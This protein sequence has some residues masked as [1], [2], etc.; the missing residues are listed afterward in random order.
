MLCQIFFWFS[1]QIIFVSQ[2]QNSSALL[3]SLEWLDDFHSPN[4]Q[5]KQWTGQV[6]SGPNPMTGVPWVII[7]QPFYSNFAMWHDFRITRSFAAI[8]Q[9][10]QCLSS[11]TG[12]ATRK[13]VMQ[14]STRWS[15]AQVFKWSQELL[16]AD[17]DALQR[18]DRGL[19]MG[20]VTYLEPLVL[21]LTKKRRPDS[22][23]V[24][25]LIQ[26]CSRQTSCPLMNFSFFPLLQDFKLA[27]V[28]RKTQWLW[29]NDNLRRVV[30][31]SRRANDTSMFSLPCLDHLCTIWLI[32][33]SNAASSIPK[34]RPWTNP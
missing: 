26:I 10:Y 27:V 32:A 4:M 2:I 8:V 1:C 34:S 29:R 18:I 6:S 9:M 3:L 13:V 7:L 15:T 23:D 31:P 25:D 22:S 19:A 20:N 5:E 24:G 12:K 16:R 17:L 21:W 30:W 33:I 14:A 11:Q 28:D